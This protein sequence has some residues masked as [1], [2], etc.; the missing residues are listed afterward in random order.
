MVAWWSSLS[1]LQQI[2]AGIAIPATVILILQT[3]LLLFGMGFDG[4]GDV[5]FDT[6]A[7]G[8]VDMDHSGDVSGLRLFTVRG[9]VAFF[10]VGGWLGV[11]AVEAGMKAVWAVLLSLLG[12]LVT[13]V[14]MAL[15]FKWIFGL[16]ESGNNDYNSAIG[17]TAEVYITIPEK[18]KGRGKII[19]TVSSQLTE[20]DAVN[21]GDE[22]I[23]PRT[24]VIITGVSGENTYIVK[25]CE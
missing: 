20:V 4:D 21:E 5:D 11:V 15:F 22:P 1:L 14:I 13:M 8:D 17:T 2:F 12:G 7:D 10:S 23:K 16:Q 19:A 24:Q 6:D 3:V 25:P 9:M 18:G